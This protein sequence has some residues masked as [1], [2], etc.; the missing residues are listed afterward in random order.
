MFSRQIPRGSKLVRPLTV[1]PTTGFAKAPPAV[2]DPIMI[3]PFTL[4]FQQYDAKTA[5]YTDVSVQYAVEWDDDVGGGGGLCHTLFGV[6]STLWQQ[7][8]IQN[9]QRPRVDPGSQV[10]EILFPGSNKIPIDGAVAADLHIVQLDPGTD[11]WYKSN[12]FAKFG[13]ISPYDSNGTNSPQQWWN[14]YDQKVSLDSSFSSGVEIFLNGQ[15]SVG[16]VELYKGKNP[17][18][19]IFSGFNGFSGTYDQAGLHT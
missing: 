16:V 2:A 6:L 8:V 11:Y 12:N 7:L 10:Q 1:F 3:V 5:E 4:Q 14:F 17:E 15:I 19:I 13:W 9:N 18:P